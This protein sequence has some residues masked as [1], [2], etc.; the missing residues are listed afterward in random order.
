MEMLGILR[1]LWD[2]LCMNVNNLFQH[3]IAIVRLPI[4]KYI[5]T[6]ASRLQYI[7]G[8]PHAFSVTM[9]LMSRRTCSK[10]DIVLA[11]G[12]FAVQ[13]KYRDLG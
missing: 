13:F 2:I 3:A 8:I 12:T 6:E 10:K 1:E 11:V 4:S 9:T 7:D 5:R